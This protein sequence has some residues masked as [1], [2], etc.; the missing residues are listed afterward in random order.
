MALETAFAT[1]SASPPREFP[2]F[3]K[4]EPLSQNPTK[5]NKFTHTKKETIKPIK[6]Q[7]SLKKR[8]FLLFIFYFL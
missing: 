7:Q 2:L 5:K 6:V 3:P 4:A 1:P 8:N